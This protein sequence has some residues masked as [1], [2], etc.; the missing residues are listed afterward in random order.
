METSTETGRGDPLPIVVGVD[1]SRPSDRAVEWA[2]DRAV[3]TGRALRLIFVSEVWPYDIPFH[4]APHDSESLTWTGNQVLAE[5]EGVALACRPEVKVECKLAVGGAVRVLCDGSQ[6]ASELVVGNRGLGGFTGLLL[7]SVSAGVT[8]YA[9][10]P[11]VVVRGEAGGRRGEAAVGVSLKED[12]PVLEYAFEEA[13]SRSL[14]LRVV[15]AIPLPK[16]TDEE[17]LAADLERSKDRARARIAEEC[18]VARRR[19]PQVEVVEDVVQDRPA[20]TLVAASCKAD[21][22]VVGAERS[23]PEARLPRRHAVRHALVHHADC[24]V[25]LVRARG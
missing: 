7:G 20:A 10:S 15:H 22:V 9:Q 3:R 25:A 23:Q 12:A 6:H 19:F 21:L 11:V 16:G 4:T 24:P 18:T 5:A 2:A 13:A 14:R 8:A 17:H 1:G